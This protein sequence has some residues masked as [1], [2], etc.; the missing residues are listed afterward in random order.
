[1]STVRLFHE[2][3][4]TEP[5]LCIYSNCEAQA[6]VGDLKLVY[7]FCVYFTI[8]ILR[9]HKMLLELSRLLHY[10]IEWQ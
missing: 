8:I 7:G 3:P 1:M 5:N 6:T 4:S 9:T 2:A 10:T